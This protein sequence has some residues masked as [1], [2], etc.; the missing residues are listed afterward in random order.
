[1]NGRRRDLKVALYVGLGGRLA[2]NFRV[3][4]NEGQVLTLLRGVSAL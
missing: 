4:V 3:I 2:V 1:M